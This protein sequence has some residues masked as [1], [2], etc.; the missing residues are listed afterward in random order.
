MKG[1]NLDVWPGNLKT[2]AHKGCAWLLDFQLE[3]CGSRVENF[4]SIFW[5]NGVTIFRT[6]QVFNDVGMFCREEMFADASGEVQNQFGWYNKIWYQVYLRRLVVLHVYPGVWGYPRGFWLSCFPQSFS[7][8]AAC[9]TA[10]NLGLWR[11]H[12]MIASDDKPGVTCDHVLPCTETEHL[13]EQLHNRCG[14]VSSFWWHNRHIRSLSP[15]SNFLLRY[16]FVVSNC[17]SIRLDIP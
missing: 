17:C 11:N 3:A 2:A 5:T 7:V 16:T 1:I 15:S 12:T 8:G 10:S 13:A 14:T 9:T 6:S 4:E